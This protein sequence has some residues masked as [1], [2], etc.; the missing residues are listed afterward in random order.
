MKLV[1]KVMPKQVVSFGIGTDLRL[2]N[3][4]IMAYYPID[5][6]CKGK[7][8]G[9]T[10]CNGVSCHVLKGSHSKGDCVILFLRKVRKDRTTKRP[11][12]RI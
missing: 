5:L 1:V 8:L 6:T 4:A 2:S 11:K 9:Y 10:I 3:G 7:Y 12:M